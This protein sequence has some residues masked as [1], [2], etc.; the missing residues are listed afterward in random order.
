MTKHTFT[1]ENLDTPVMQGWTIDAALS[2]ITKALDVAKYEYPLLAAPDG[3]VSVHIADLEVL[4][5][6][7]NKLGG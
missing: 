5:V 6:Y 2:N 3:K 4:L 1:V 7:I